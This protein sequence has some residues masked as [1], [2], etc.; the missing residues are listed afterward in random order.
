VV[1]LLSGR[2]YRAVP[3]VE[4]GRLV[5][6][7]TGT[8]LAERGGLRVRPQLLPQLAASDLQRH[9]DEL[10][11]TSARV[12]D[13]MT[14]RPVCIAPGT[15]LPDAAR[16]MTGRRLKRLP[17]VD[18][19]GLLLG[20]LSRYDIL[21]S[22][23]GGAGAADASPRAAGLAAGA[24]LS[25]VMRRDVPTV[26]P[27][28]PLAETLQAVV[29]TRL[30][31]AVV[32][33]E[34]RRVVGLVSDAAVLERITPAL[35]HGALRSLMLRL[36]FTHPRPGEVEAAAHTRAQ[37]AADLMTGALPSAPEETALSDAIALMLRDHHKVL[38][39]TGRGGTL[40]GVVDRA[41]LLRGVGSGDG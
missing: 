8:D 40:V 4:Q 20:M 12:A 19:G 18:Q 39:V 37:T 31:L 36:P 22:V 29:S 24:P 7:V 34:A 11:G 33:D 26:H 32:V 9:L 2:S 35:R 27:G 14:P 15:P 10:A 30:N 28:T 1:A 41:D 3:V 38:A 21:R 6:I 16:L 25:S 17:V 13:I 23:A 5:G